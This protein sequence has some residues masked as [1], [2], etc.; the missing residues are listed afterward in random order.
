[1]TREEIEKQITSHM[2][3]EEFLR[4]QE[5]LAVLRKDEDMKLKALAELQKAY[6]VA[7][8][9]QQQEMVKDAVGQIREISRKTR[10]EI[11]ALNSVIYKHMP[12]AEA[13]ELYEEYM[14]FTAKTP[15]T[16]S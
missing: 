10:E 2:P 7:N 8:T 6:L 16:P 9:D 15:K 13:K 3:L 11:R 12:L 4:I 14:N 5:R 1:M